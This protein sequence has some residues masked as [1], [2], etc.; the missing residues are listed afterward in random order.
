VK[1]NLRGEQ[2]PPPVLALNLGGRALGIFQRLW[3]VLLHNVEELEVEAG[4]H[5]LQ[6]E[7]GGFTLH[8]SCTKALN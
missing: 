1:A 8:P 3:A 5:L 4:A 6:N 2:P 7:D